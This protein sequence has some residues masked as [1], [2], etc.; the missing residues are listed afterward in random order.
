MAATA[1]FSPERA[2]VPT[3]ALLFPNSGPAGSIILI[4]G[5]NFNGVRAVDC[6]S[7]SAR[8]DVL[9]AQI[10][11]VQVPTGI[12]GTVDVTLHTATWTITQADKFTV[13]SGGF[14]GF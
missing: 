1:M 9:V 10:M 6:G 3:V 13:R 11:I 7:T 4:F 2:V 8:F 14:G 5:T 12:S